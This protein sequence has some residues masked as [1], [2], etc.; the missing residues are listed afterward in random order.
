MQRVANCLL[1]KGDQVLLLKKPRRGWWVAPGGKMEPT[2]TILETVCREYR[3]ETGLILENPTLG[4]VFTMCMENEGK[5]DKEWMMFTFLADSH[6]GEM[7]ERSPEG[8]LCWQPVSHVP[9]LPTSGMDRQIL[10]RLLRPEGALLIGK[11]V[12]SPEEELLS[13]AW[14]HTG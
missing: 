12:Y 8:E 4:G 7:L 10:T 13:H 6:R 5:R 11:L 2:E 9:S 14:H 1:R 3:E